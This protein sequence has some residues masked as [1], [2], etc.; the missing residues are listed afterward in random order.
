MVVRKYGFKR[1]NRD[2]SVC[3]FLLLEPNTAYSRFFIY[4]PFTFPSSISVKDFQNILLE[5][6]TFCLYLPQYYIFDLR[7]LYLFSFKTLCTFI[8]VGVRHVYRDFYH[9]WLLPQR[10][11]F[12]ASTRIFFSLYL[13]PPQ[14]FKCPPARQLPLS[15]PMSY[16]G[17]ED[18]APMEALLEIDTLR[19]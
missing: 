16:L 2:S 12:F 11:S 7:S 13:R 5:C 17:E 4:S 8:G 10:A 19:A 15:I 14:N 1:E 9:I 6:Y 18:L 3:I